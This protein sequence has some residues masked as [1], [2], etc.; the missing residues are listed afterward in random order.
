MNEWMN[1]WMN[2]GR[3]GW[4]NKRLTEW[5]KEKNERMGK[6]MNGCGQ[7]NRRHKLCYIY[8]GRNRCE[9]EY[10]ELKRCADRVCS[11]TDNKGEVAEGKFSNLSWNQRFALHLKD[12]WVFFPF[13]DIWYF[14]Q[15]LTFTSIELNRFAKQAK[16]L[17]K[18]L[19]QKRWWSSD[20][21]PRKTPVAQKH[22]VVSRQEK[23]AFFTPPPPSGCLATPRPL[24]Q[25]LYGCTDVRWRHN[26]ISRI[27]RLPNL[28]SN[29]ASL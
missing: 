27:N 12:I 1:E 10:C 7:K 24:P 16:L 17:K 4:I 2:E 3:E 19:F 25:S 28:L 8:L 22:Y 21:P 26:Q 23:M 14:F 20:F 18:P 5:T 13:I 15:V 6:W 9:N 29:G 11:R